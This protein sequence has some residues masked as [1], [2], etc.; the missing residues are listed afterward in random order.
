MA[1]SLPPLVVVVL[2][3]CMWKFRNDA[4]RRYLCC[5]VGG[6]SRQ[7]VMSLQQENQR[8]RQELNQSK[9]NSSGRYS[10]GHFGEEIQSRQLLHWLLPSS[11]RLFT[12]TSSSSSPSPGRESVAGVPDGQGGTLPALKQGGGRGLPSPFT[13]QSRS[14]SSTQP[15]PL[16][17]QV[18]QGGPEHQ[19]CWLNP[20]HSSSF[21]S[22]HAPLQRGLSQVSPMPQTTPTFRSPF[23]PTPSVFSPQ[24]STTIGV[25][26][27]Q[28]RVPRQVWGEGSREEGGRRVGCMAASSVQSKTASYECASVRVM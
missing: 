27:N 9:I 21:L 2:L 6:A 10:Q 1:P 16:S 5:C 26:A 8:L 22:L 20:N 25:L 15:P 12:L 3:L 17:L 11:Q 23:T 13:P 19:Q 7:A 24:P 14:V 4:F 28:Q 18:S